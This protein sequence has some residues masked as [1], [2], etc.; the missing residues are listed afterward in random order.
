MTELWSKCHPSLNMSGTTLC[1]SEGNW[2]LGYG[3]V[4]AKTGCHEWVI[5]YSGS[6]SWWYIGLVSNFS[7]FHKDMKEIKYNY[8]YYGDDGYVYGPTQDK[9]K[10]V[11]IW[12]SGECVKI[13]LDLKNK[14]ISFSKSSN[15]PFYTFEN[16]KETNGWKLCGLVGNNS[17][18]LDIVSYRKISQFD[19]MLGISKNCVTSTLNSLNIQHNQL[20]KLFV[21]TNNEIKELKNINNES[22]NKNIKLKT[23]ITNN[24]LNNQ[25]KELRITQKVKGFMNV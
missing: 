16:I 11:P 8:S 23:T 15:N 10:S 5:K 2:G 17:G 14:I 6:G 19:V 20:V 3:S 21:D 1:A 12:K 18:K 9:Y 24:N 4:L 25:N 22:N 13:I 7:H